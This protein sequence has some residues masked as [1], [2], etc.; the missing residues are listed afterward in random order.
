MESQQREILT[1]E[2][3]A[4]RWQCN[5]Q[6]VYDA[7]WQ[8]VNPLRLINLSRVEARRHGKG[9]KKLRFRIRDVQDWESLNVREFKAPEPTVRRGAGTMALSYAEANEPLRRGKTRP[10]NASG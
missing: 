4:A 3:V 8:L 10:R 7:V 9:P 1:V 6:D 5:V 2:D